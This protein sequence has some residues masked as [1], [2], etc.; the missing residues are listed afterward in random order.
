MLGDIFNPK[1]SKFCHNSTFFTGLWFE[2]LLAFVSFITVTDFSV[3]LSFEMGLL[4]FFSV[5]LCKN[6]L[7]LHSLKYNCFQV[8][9]PEVSV[10]EP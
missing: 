2:I 7:C 3:T 1:S 6:H 10:D 8:P 5:W 4:G 9:L